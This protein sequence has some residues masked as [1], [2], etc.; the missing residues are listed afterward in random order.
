MQ[1]LKATEDDILRISKLVNSAYRGEYSKKG[2][3]T[4]ADL[5]G[6]QRTDPETLLSMMNEKSSFY[7]VLESEKLLGCVN[8]KEIEPNVFYFG[9]L[10]VE[11]TAQ[12]SGIGKFLIQEIE[13]LAKNLGGKEIRL[14][15]IDL[16][17]E[18]IA[19]YLRRGYE[20]TGNFE[21]FPENDPKF[22]I[23]KTKMKLLEFKKQF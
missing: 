8:F 15:V 7:L 11:P 5:L 19:Y 13:K 18:L 21:P 2:W 23:P 9:M 1:F 3:T 10:T 4:E 22:G 14:T 6:G 20:S 12:N 17:S 16:R